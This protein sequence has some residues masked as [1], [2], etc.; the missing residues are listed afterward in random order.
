MREGGGGVWWWWD[1]YRWDDEF[2]E[3]R[4]QLLGEGSVDLM[5]VS[6]EWDRPL[7]RPNASNWRFSASVQVVDFS[8]SQKLWPSTC[9]SELNC[10]CNTVVTITPWLGHGD[11]KYWLNHHQGELL[12]FSESGIWAPVGYT[13][14]SPIK[15][16]RMYICLKQNRQTSIPAYYLNSS[17]PGFNDTALP[18]LLKVTKALYSRSR[19]QSQENIS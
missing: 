19:F 8:D 17:S 16:S 6:S 3:L 1:E 4:H 13:D 10:Y 9:K 2:R 12:S 7:H 11:C 14:T 5:G 18:R 15:C